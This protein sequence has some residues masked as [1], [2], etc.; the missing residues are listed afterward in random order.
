M[1]DVSIA[2]AALIFFSPV[3]L[4]ISCAILMESGG[5]ILFSQVRL[6]RHGSHFHILKF[7]K[8]RQ[9][10]GSSGLPLTLRH[11]P[12]MS[13]VGRILA[14]TKLDELPQLINVLRG[15]MAIV[16][17]RPESLDFADCF[18]STSR[19]ILEYLP[20]I[21]GPSQA[22]LRNECRFYPVSSDP[23]PFYRQ[24]LFPL[25][26]SIDLAYYPNRSVL[27]DLRWILVGV[28]AVFGLDR[29]SITAVPRLAAHRILCDVDQLQRLNLHG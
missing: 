23:A 22:A 10:Q 4:L 11:D 19:Q 18:M 24:V 6:G 13:P 12:R 1:L 28:L 25:K 5:P 3:I 27:S 29:S 8:F 26:M 7:R 15:E 9:K 20:G 14:R 2:L 21:F 16:G 17:P